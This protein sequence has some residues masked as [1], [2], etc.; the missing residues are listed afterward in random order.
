MTTFVGGPY[1]GQDLPYDP[2][3]ARHVRMPDPGARVQPGD[4]GTVDADWPHIYEADLKAD[5]PVFRFVRSERG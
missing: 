1:N 4:V 2:R 3:S 5:P